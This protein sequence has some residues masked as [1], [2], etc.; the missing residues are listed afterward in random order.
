MTKS[1]VKGSLQSQ[2]S[3]I[4]HTLFYYFAKYSAQFQE[5]YLSSLAYRGYTNKPDL[6]HIG[7]DTVKQQTWFVCKSSWQLNIESFTEIQG[8]ATLWKYGIKIINLDFTHWYIIFQ[9]FAISYSFHFPSFAF[10]IKYSWTWHWKFISRQVIHCWET[11][12]FNQHFC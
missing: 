1:V 2:W 11:F 4:C 12:L 7:V 3:I 8:V 5:T 9:Y 10:A 6:L